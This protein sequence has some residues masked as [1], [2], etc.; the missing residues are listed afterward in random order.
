MWLVVA[1]ILKLIIK[2]RFPS[3]VTNYGAPSRSKFSTSFMLPQLHLYWLNLI[4]IG[5]TSFILAQLHLYWLNF[6]YASSTPFI[7]AQLHLCI[8][9]FIYIALTFFTMLD[10][11]HHAQLFLPCSTFFTMLNFGVEAMM[12]KFMN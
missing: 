9:N 12:T 2:L 10:F 11:F 4:Y 3:D 7:L 1:I 8:L 6:I 5:S